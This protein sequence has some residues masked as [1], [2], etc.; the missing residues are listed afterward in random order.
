MSRRKVIIDGQEVDFTVVQPDATQLRATITPSGDMARKAY[1]DRNMSVI[2]MYYAASLGAHALTERWRYTVPT[3]RKAMH[4]VLMSAA[5]NAIE[6]SGRRCFCGHQYSDDGGVTWKYY[7]L[8]YHISTVEFCTHQTITA[9]FGMVAG[10]MI[11][12]VT[13]HNDTAVH[14]MYVE[15]LLSEFDS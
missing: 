8:L 4:S 2:S 15:I 3:G 11:R 12:G 5:T 13:G 9:T 10:D 7:A 6:T 1:Y 14:T